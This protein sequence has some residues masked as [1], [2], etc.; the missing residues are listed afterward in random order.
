MEP[1]IEAVPRHVDKVIT[2]MP[3]QDQE[4]IRYALIGLEQQKRSIEEKISEIQA[5]LGDSELEAPKA[6]SVERRRKGMSKAGR[7]RIAAAQRAG[8]QLTGKR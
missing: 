4:L 1:L 6:R 8:G 3:A 2:D 5:M 7:D